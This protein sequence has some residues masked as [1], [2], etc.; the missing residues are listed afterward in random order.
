MSDPDQR[1]RKA[2]NELPRVLRLIETFRAA[3]TSR[4]DFARRHRLHPSALSRILRIGELPDALLEELAAFERLSRTHLEVIAT[5]PEERRPELIARAREGRSTYSLR[6]RRETT[7]V[8][9]AATPTTAIETPEAEGRD[10]SPDEQNASAE[11]DPRA[12]ELADTLGASCEETRAFALE[13]LSV[14]M[15]GSPERVRSSLEQFRAARRA[16][17]RA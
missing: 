17:S 9:V 4:R 16:P 14:L 11:T 2:M 1:S 7:A 3:Q 8:A 13:L 10:E 12:R 5:A 6:E 15:K